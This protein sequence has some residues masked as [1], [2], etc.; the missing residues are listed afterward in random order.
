[1]V[2]ATVAMMRGQGNKKGQ[3]EKGGWEIRRE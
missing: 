3:T 2:T 1:M